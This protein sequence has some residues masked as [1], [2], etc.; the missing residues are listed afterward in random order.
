[1]HGNHGGHDPLLQVQPQG[2]GF[3]YPG[4]ALR[5]YSALRALGIQVDFV[6]PGGDLAG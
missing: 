6:P 2:G 1:M 3:S 4:L 5:F